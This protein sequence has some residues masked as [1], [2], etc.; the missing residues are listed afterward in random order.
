MQTKNETVE[1]QKCCFNFSSKIYI[2]QEKKITFIKIT[3]KFK[4]QWIV[5]K[6]QKWK[7]K[8]QVLQVL[9]V[10]QNPWLTSFIPISY[11]ERE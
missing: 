7:K 11:K 5:Y 3:I 2:H 10:H 6:P 1:R 9:R 4:K 8:K